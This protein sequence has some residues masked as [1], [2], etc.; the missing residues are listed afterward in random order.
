MSKTADITLFGLFELLYTPFGLRNASQT[1]QRFVD[2][3]LRSLPFVYAYIDDLLVAGSTSEEH[4]EHLATVFDRYQQFGVVLNQ[5]T[6]VFGVPPQNSSNIWLAPTASILFHRKL[7]LHRFLGMV[8]FY[9]QLLP[10]CADT[11]LPLRS[12]L[13]S[14]KGSFE[15]SAGA[16]AAF[17]KVK[18]ALA[19]ATLLTHFSPNAPISI[20]VDASNVGVGAVL[21]QH[22]AGHTQPLAFFSRKLSPAETRYGTFERE[23]IAVGDFTVFTGHSPLPFALKSTSDKLKPREIHQLDHISQSTSGIHHIDGSCN[24]VAGALSRPSITPLQLSPG[25]DLAEMA[26]EQGRVGCPCD[27]DA[28]GLQLQDLPLTA[29]NGAILCDIPAVSQRLFV[30]P[31]LRRNV[32]SSL[33]NL[34]PGSRATDKLVSDRLFW[35][36][37]N[38]DL[39]LLQ[40]SSRL[41]SCTTVYYLA[42]KKAERFHRQLKTSLRA[43]DDPQK[44][45]G[46][47]AL[48]LLGIRSPLKPDLDC[49][50][51][52]LVFSATPDFS[53][54]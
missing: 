40:Q 18:A 36:G 7:G 38:K 48:V 24:E 41:F 37:M 44:Q 27:E 46:D 31:S 16:L 4:M 43:V 14:P 54:R 50:A 21:Q 53:V 6:Y 33:H 29:G 2:R 52:E 17:D 26:A 19:D 47:L 11:I 45:A 34:H 8:N 51:A 49:S 23:L 3:V 15:L 28:S 30:P 12:L 32:F 22:L 25:I 13:S 42:A 10:H 35:P 5:S 1:F 20:M 9:R 39:K